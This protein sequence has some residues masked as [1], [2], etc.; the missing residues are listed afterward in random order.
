MLQKESIGNL[1]S[2]YTNWEAVISRSWSQMAKNLGVV[3]SIV[4]RSWG[5]SVHISEMGKLTFLDSY[6][7]NFSL[8]I[9][10][11]HVSWRI[12]GIIVPKS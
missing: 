4:D 9:V 1:V 8:S 2:L 6:S 10:T 3:L 5:S 11:T 7:Q 12:L